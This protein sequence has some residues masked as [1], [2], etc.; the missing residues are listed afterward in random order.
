MDLGDLGVAFE[1]L[2][3]LGV[4]Y[5]ILSLPH[6]VAS[7]RI[8]NACPNDSSDRLAIRNDREPVIPCSYDSRPLHFDLAG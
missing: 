4:W 5:R 3:G 2:A 1:S 7:G 6:L 8:R